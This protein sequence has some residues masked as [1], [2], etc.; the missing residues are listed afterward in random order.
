MHVLHVI[1]NSKLIEKLCRTLIIAS[2]EKTE[3]LISGRK[4][5]TKNSEE[6]EKLLLIHS[7]RSVVQG[8]K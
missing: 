7:A 6:Q 4:E 8:G 2:I 5:I 3:G 1:I